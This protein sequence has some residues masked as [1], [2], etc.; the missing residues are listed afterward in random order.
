MVSY[1][2][3]VILPPSARR[4]RSAREHFVVPI[5]RCYELVALIRTHWRGLAGGEEVWAEIAHFFE[6]LRGQA[7]TEAG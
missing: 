1:P 3:R 7:G 4:A 2:G 5:D 6:R